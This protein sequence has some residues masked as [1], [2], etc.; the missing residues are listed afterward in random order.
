MKK[1]MRFC[2]LKILS[3]RVWEKMLMLI[4][5]IIDI[6]RDQNLLNVALESFENLFFSYKTFFSVKNLVGD[7]MWRGKISFDKFFLSNEQT[8]KVCLLCNLPTLSL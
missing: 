2:R 4:A 1:K 7:E 6:C 3:G 8:A 5:V